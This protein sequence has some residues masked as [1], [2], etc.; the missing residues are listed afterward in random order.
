LTKIKIH[1]NISYMIKKFI[2]TTIIGMAIAIS[3]VAQ[4]S[5]LAP[6][7]SSPTNVTGQ[8]TVSIV[9]ELVSGVKSSGLLEATNYAFEPYATYAPK[10]PKGDRVGGGALA[11]YNLNNYL[12]AGIGLDY[13]GHFSLVS[14]NVSVKYPIS[15]GEQLFSKDAYLHSL[16]FVPFVLGGIGTAM[17]GTGGSSISTIEDA[18]A[19]FQFGKLA[20]GK[21]NIGACY[22]Q[23]TGAGAYSGQRYHMFAGWSHGF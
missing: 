9:S 5:T 14:G 10:A 12:G 3:A 8:T 17:G 1:S 7:D 20:G 22:G 13:L 6:I 16:K 23:W 21:F 19:Y 18:G 15:V 2:T 4:T 11:I